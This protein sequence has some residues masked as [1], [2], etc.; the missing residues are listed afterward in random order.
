[1]KALIVAL[2]LVPLQAPEAVPGSSAVQYDGS[3]ALVS[4]ACTKP[5]GDCSGQVSLALVDAP[6]AAIAGPGPYTVG[7]E[8]TDRV[9]L[10]V[11]G[12]A[13]DGVRE[14]LVV[15]DGTSQVRQV[16]RI[17]TDTGIGEGQVEVEPVA[18][19]R[20]CP[21]VRGATRIR[22]RGVECAAA[23]SLVRS[24]AAKRT[25]RFGV[26][27]FACRRVSADVTCTRGD[28]RVRWRRSGR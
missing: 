5:E 13:L 9:R 26:R 16:E 1:M 28:G 24:A 18:R 25:A 3:T 17:A 12:G 7:A 19:E 20:S 6:G 4:V 14:V 21:A 27:G 8:G 23:R 2:S 10:S 15:V 22:A 11:P